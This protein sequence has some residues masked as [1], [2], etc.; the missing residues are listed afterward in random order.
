MAQDDSFNAEGPTTVAFETISPTPARVPAFGV[1]VFAH[2]CGVNGVALSDIPAGAHRVAPN[3]VGVHGL[4]ESEGVQGEG[5]TGVHGIARIPGAFGGGQGTGVLGDGGRFGVRG[6]GDVGVK[7][8]S[9]NVG[10]EGFGTTGVLGT[11]DVGVRGSGDTIGVHGVCDS[12]RG[13]VFQTGR[14]R[15]P[16][17]DRF[18][19]RPSAQVLLVPVRVNGSVDGTLPR[20]GLAGDLFVAVDTRE[21]RAA[22]AELWFCVRDGSADLARP[23]AVWSKVDFVRTH[24]V[25]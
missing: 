11:G 1:A 8:E 5:P 16:P 24:S 12:N 14:E 17:I 19:G 2:Q 23:G 6:T 22:T 18:A 20:A 15:L 4:G 25:P 21:A 3:L 7:G 9:P 10:V 13:G